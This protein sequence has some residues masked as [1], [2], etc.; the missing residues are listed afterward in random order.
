MRDWIIAFPQRLARI[1]RRTWFFKADFLVSR[2][3]RF[4]SDPLQNRHT[5]ILVDDSGTLKW[6]CLGCPGGC[7]QIISLSLNPNQRPRWQ[8]S[9]DVWGRPT[10]SPSVHQKNACGCHFWLK[11]GEV[12]W[13]KDGRPV[14][15]P[16]SLEPSHMDGTR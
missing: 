11:Q 15:V 12:K 6:A 4:P 8:I 2:Q 10:L 1:L 7:G 3:T 16:G 14:R 5:L 9:V 13:C